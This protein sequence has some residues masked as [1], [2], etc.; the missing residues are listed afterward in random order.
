MGESSSAPAHLGSDVSGSGRW[1]LM[2]RLRDSVRGETRRT[3][4]REALWEE[5]NKGSWGGGAPF[6]KKK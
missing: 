5:R 3:S 6:K 2:R 1:V 4:R